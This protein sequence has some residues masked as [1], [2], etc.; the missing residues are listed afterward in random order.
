MENRK[1]IL[2]ELTTTDPMDKKFTDEQ[3]GTLGTAVNALILKQHEIIQAEEA[4][5][6]LKRHERILNQ[7]TIPMLMENLGFE[8]IT[9]DGKKVSVKD[10]V[11]ISI[12]AAQKPGAFVWMDKNG[13]GDLIKIALTAKFARG[14]S[15]LA[16][17][18][19]DALLDIG[20]SPNQTEAV[21]PGTLKAWAREE[22]SQGHSLPQEFFKIHVVKLTTVK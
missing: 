8:S 14:E 2:D 1:T 6:D 10:S 22:L 5:K 4:L 19:F 21:H 20:A 13:H 17:E 16:G 11:Q 12:P 7:D 3:M 15:Q 9:V 18:A